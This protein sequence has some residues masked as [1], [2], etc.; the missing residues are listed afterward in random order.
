MKGCRRCCNA[1]IGSRSIV[2]VTVTPG[3]AGAVRR[4]TL[5]LLL[6]PGFSPWGQ[7]ARWSTTCLR[8]VPR[9]QLGD[10]Q[11]AA[12]TAS[13]NCAL[14]P[15]N[16]APS[17]DSAPSRLS[18]PQCPRTFNQR[19]PCDVPRFNTPLRL[20]PCAL[21]PASQHPQSH[22]AELSSSPAH[23]HATPSLP[24][25]PQTVSPPRQRHV[26]QTHDANRAAQSRTRRRQDPRPLRGLEQQ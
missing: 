9:N 22:A 10:Q 24:S 17:H 16:P 8:A 12:K 14:S 20:L 13:P 6:P 26:Q 18:P 2:M 5:G 11:T 7:L 4:Q 15:R 1:G 3:L 25:P 19:R 21:Q 23:P